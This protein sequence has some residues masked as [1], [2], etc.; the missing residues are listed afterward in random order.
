M[1]TGLA[2]WNNNLFISLALTINIWNIPP[3][4]L[5][6]M[7]FFCQFCTT[8]TFGNSIDITWRMFILSG[9][10]TYRIFFPLTKNCSK[11]FL[12]PYGSVKCTSF[13]VMFIKPSTISIQ[14][15]MEDSFRNSTVVVLPVNPC[16]RH[17]SEFL[18]LNFSLFD[19]SILIGIIIKRVQVN[20]SCKRLNL[21]C[22]WQ[23]LQI[24]HAIT[25]VN[26]IRETPNL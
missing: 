11:K 25:S 15:V 22:A 12:F 17:T 4:F 14:P 5:H 9:I 2:I 23:H 10:W 6:G 8:F 19:I 20:F 3:G 21:L 13:I 1:I 26:L 16:K 18:D 24:R 7:V